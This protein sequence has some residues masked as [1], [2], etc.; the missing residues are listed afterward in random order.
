MQH[1]PKARANAL[2]IT[3][4]MIFPC[5]IS[6]QLHF[7]GKPWKWKTTAP[8]QFAI[9]LLHMFPCLSHY[10]YYIKQRDK[11]NKWGQCGRDIGV[12]MI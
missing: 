1:E 7:K 6:R 2:V 5:Y 4:A 8:K 3:P 12:C 9:M 10:S 11:R